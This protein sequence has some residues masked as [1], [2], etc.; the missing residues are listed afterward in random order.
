[1][2]GQTTLVASAAISFF[3][4]RVLIAIEMKTKTGC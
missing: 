2:L 3:P 1:M 4:A